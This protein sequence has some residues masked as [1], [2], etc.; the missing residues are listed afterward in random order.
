MILISIIPVCFHEILASFP[1][2]V[3]GEGNTDIASLTFF[4]LMLLTEKFVLYSGFSESLYT[5]QLF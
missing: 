2:M 3:D 1:L 5:V 4:V